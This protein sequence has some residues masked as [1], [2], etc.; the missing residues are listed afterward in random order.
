MKKLASLLLCTVLVTALV[1]PYVISAQTPQMAPDQKAFTDANRIKEPAKKIEALE[2]FVV[3]FPNSFS[4]YSA[5]QAIFTTLVK[6]FPE[7]KG[8]IIT[9]AQ[10]AIDKAPEPIKSF[11]YNNLANTLLDAGLMPEK[12]EEFAQQGLTATDEEMAKMTAQRRAP[13]QVAL[14]RAYLRNG[15]LAKAE[16][17]L[18]EAYKTSPS[19]MAAEALAEVA[20]K[21]GDEAGALDYY[22]SAAVSG[23]V[24]PESRKKLEALYRKTHN[25]SLDGLEAMLDAKYAKAYPNPVHDTPYQATASRTDRTVLAEVFTGAGCP[26]CVAADLAFDVILERYPRKDVIVLMYHQHIPQPDPMTNPATLERAKYY[27]VDR[28]GVPSY[29]FDGGAIQSGGGAREAT[30]TSYNR[31]KPEIEKLLEKSAEAAIKLEAAL[32]DTTVKASATIDN[33]KSESK[34]LKVHLLLVED[35]LRYAGENGVRFHPMVVRSL[36]GEKGAGFAVEAGKVGS[37]KWEFNIPAIIAEAKKHLDD[38]E[39]TGRSEPFTFSEKKHEIN[40]N[41]LAVVAFVQDD[42]TKA[43]LQSTYVSL[44]PVKENAAQTVQTEKKK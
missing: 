26:P 7:Q 18:K 13:A 39:Q 40:A 25:G 28:R 23:K 34:D 15:K 44:K 27:G 42:K 38:F 36:G 14:G 20:E 17:L 30:K 37:V 41:Q 43:I 24:K 1:L 29:T 12:A 6:N 16:P 35:Q 3:D 31:F 5:H 33:I 8:K 21:K 19:A 32:V 11:T 10:L 9:Q 22:T 2:K 4:L